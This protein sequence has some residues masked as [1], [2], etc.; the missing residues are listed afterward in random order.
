MLLNRLY[1][2]FPQ[3][4]SDENLDTVASMRFSPWLTLKHQNQK[5]SKNLYFPSLDM[6]AKMIHLI[7]FFFCSAV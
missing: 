5:E 7:M 3:T 2:V 6:K 1:F 4:W